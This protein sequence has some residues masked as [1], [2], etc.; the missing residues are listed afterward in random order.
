MQFEKIT[1][2]LRFVRRLDFDFTSSLQEN[3]PYDARF[4]YV[5]S[6]AS[7]IVAAGTEYKMEKGSMIFIPAGTAY[8]LCTPEGSVSYFAINFDFTNKSKSRYMPIPPC[9]PELFKDNEI[10]ERAYFSDIQCFNSVLFLGDMFSLL[11]S[12]EEIEK[13]YSRKAVLYETK[14]SSIF[15]EIL[16]KCARTISSPKN[17]DGKNPAELIISY[18]HEN[19]KSPLTNAQIAGVFGFH[20][21]YIS[22]LVKDYTGL[23]L[24]KYLISIRLAVSLRLL[25]EGALSVSETADACG[26]CDIYHFSKY[27]KSAF[28]KCPSAYLKR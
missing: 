25:E 16:I 26:F 7:S 18:I 11:S 2:F 1:P 20:P 19:Y 21:N 27:F 13:E 5:L 15:T 9:I 8:R 4:F 12:L 6:G 23:P 10:T 28:G 14:I 24:H 3:K 17:T 22:K